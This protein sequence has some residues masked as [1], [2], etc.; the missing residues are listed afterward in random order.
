[1]T[2]FE[3]MLLMVQS[4]LAEIHRDRD[5]AL[6]FQARY[7]GSPDL[8]VYLRQLEEKRALHSMM[9]DAVAELRR[10]NA[11]HPVLGLPVRATRMARAS[12]RTVAPAMRTGTDR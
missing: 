10:Q 2:L 8:D 7:G 1:M 9:V 11:N 4:G 3:H 12:L 6:T 5:R